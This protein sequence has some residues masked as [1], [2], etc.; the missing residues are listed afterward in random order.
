MAATVLDFASARRCGKTALQWH[1][2]KQESTR[3]GRP[4]LCVACERPH[5]IPPQFGRCP[6]GSYAFGIKSQ[7]QAQP[8]LDF[9]AGE[10]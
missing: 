10:A 4:I 5:T 9:H 8:G 7:H 1:Q 3:L 2:L 6:C